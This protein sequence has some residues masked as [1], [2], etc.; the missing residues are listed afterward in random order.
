MKTNTSIIQ[1]IA[2]GETSLS[3]EAVR[4]ANIILNGNLSGKFNRYAFF[5]D[6]NGEC[7]AD[8]QDCILDFACFGAE[9]GMSVDTSVDPSG[10]YE[11]GGMTPEVSLKR[12]FNQISNLPYAV[13]QKLENSVFTIRGMQGSFSYVSTYFHYCFAKGRINERKLLEMIRIA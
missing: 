2:N 12:L 5:Y 4:V 3:G 8:V 7:L 11:A 10:V 9:I 13:S 6:G 1:Q